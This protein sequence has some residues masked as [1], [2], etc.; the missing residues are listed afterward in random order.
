MLADICV[1]VAI[2]YTSSGSETRIDEVVQQITDFG[3][4]AIAIKVQADLRE[5]DAP[6]RIVKATCDVLGDSVD[7]LVNNAGFQA[8][9]T[10]G[11]ISVDDFSKHYDLNVRAIV[12]MCKAVLPHLRRPGRII[13]IGSTGARQGFAGLSLYCSSKAALEGL[14]R[15]YA[16]ELGPLG[17]TVNAVNPGPV[18]TD[19][20]QGVPQTIVESQKAT[21]PME[22]R[23]GTSDDIAQIVGFL[24]EERSRWVT[25]QSISATGGW[26]MI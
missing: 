24:A 13:N 25:G 3:N 1:K 26:H 23:L 8:T 11:E 10:L 12:L 18:A 22:N 6:E 16:A 14:T 19:L 7:I 9:K 17:H 21:T 5:T 20:L 4:G 2:T 15:C